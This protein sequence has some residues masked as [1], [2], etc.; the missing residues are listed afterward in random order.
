MISMSPLSLNVSIKMES[1]K[2]L[3]CLNIIDKNTFNISCN[4]TIFKRKILIC[5]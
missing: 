1:R 3:F 4:D 5:I 2:V